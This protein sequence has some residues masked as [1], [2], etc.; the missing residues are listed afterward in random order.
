MN[1]QE[2]S[3]LDELTLEVGGLR[4]QISYLSRDFENFKWGV[5]N[6]AKYSKGSNINGKYVVVDCH[7]FTRYYEQSVESR[8]WLYT[9]VEIQTGDTK[10]N[11]TL[12]QLEDLA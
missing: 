9:V 7:V 11:L 5:E 8:Y 10:Y 12:K 2:K 4:T 3:I 6:P 1:K